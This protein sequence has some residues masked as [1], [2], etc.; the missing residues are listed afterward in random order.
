MQD[1]G[2][3]ELSMSEWSSL[4]IPV[5]KKD[6]SLRFCLDFRKV[7]SVSKFDAYPMPQVDDLVERLGRAKYLKYLQPLQGV[8]ASPTDGRQQGADGLQDTLWTLPPFCVALW[9]A[10]SSGD[11]LKDDGPYPEGD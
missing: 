11:I 2:V 3:I 5:S 4:V 7:N 9:P 8:L 6:G 10:R 1:L